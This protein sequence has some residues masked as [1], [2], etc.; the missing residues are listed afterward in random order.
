MYVTITHG[1]HH[2][3]TVYGP[4]DDRH[5]PVEAGTTQSAIITPLHPAGTVADLESVLPYVSRISR[6]A[7]TAIASSEPAPDQAGPVALLVV[8]AT[9]RLV[10]AIGPFATTALSHTWRRQRTD[11]PSGGIDCIPLLL[12]SPP[13]PPT[14]RPR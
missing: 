5:P 3:T 13:A 9:V 2:P 8:A 12:T 10:I 6:R 11:L 1:P 4:I 7:A 14:R